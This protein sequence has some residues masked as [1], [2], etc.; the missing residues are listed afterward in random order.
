MGQGSLVETIYMHGR[1]RP[2]GRDG[3]YHIIFAR[4]LSQERFM[5]NPSRALVLISQ[6]PRRVRGASTPDLDVA[7]PV[8]VDTVEALLRLLRSSTK[9][10]TKGSRL[11]T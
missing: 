11:I 9:P 1:A 8:R 6:D 7:V 10:V 5:R 4:E 3:S 2:R